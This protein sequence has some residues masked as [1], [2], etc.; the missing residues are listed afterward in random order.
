MKAMKIEEACITE[1]K[2]FFTAM[3]SYYEGQEEAWITA[4]KFSYK[5]TKIHGLEGGIVKFWK[6]PES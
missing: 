6:K 4:G 3:S 2:F 1:R 5:A